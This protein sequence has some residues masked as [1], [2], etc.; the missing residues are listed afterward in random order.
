LATAQAR[1]DD[2]TFFIGESLE[3]RYLVDGLWNQKLPPKIRD[4]AP[5]RATL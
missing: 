2:L 5:H 4:A 1:D 3:Q